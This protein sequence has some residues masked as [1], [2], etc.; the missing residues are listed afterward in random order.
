[1]KAVEALRKKHGDG[2][3]TLGYQENE[4]IGLRRGDTRRGPE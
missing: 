2:S 3:I 4:E 1:M